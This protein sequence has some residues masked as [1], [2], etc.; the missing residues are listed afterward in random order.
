MSLIKINTGYDNE[1]NLKKDLTVENAI[2]LLSSNG[3]DIYELSAY[4]ALVEVEVDYDLE[5][6]STLE[7]EEICALSDD[8]YCKLKEMI[9]IDLD[10]NFEDIVELDNLRFS[11]RNCYNKLINAR[12][13]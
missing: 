7:E 12:V 1:G 10:N 3:Y 9:Y 13:K 2:K 6:Y 8:E 4:D 5:N 11:I